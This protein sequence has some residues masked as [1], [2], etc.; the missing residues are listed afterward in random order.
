[1]ITIFIANDSTL[2]LSIVVQ[3]FAGHLSFYATTGKREIYFPTQRETEKQG[4]NK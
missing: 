1:M 2:I 3:K 4:I